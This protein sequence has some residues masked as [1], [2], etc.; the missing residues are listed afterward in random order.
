MLP[1]VFFA[2]LPA[3][4][5]ESILRLKSMKTV[6]MR[7]IFFRCPHTPIT[8]VEVTFSFCLDDQFTI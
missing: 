7:K 6:F 2:T 3:L 8:Y 4:I 5:S 1:E